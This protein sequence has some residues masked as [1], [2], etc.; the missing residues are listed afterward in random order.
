M[1]RC[2]YPTGIAMKNDMLLDGNSHI[3]FE[4]WKIWMKNDIL[5][6]GNS[7]IFFKIW[8]IRRHEEWWYLVIFLIFW[9]KALYFKWLWQMFE[10]ILLCELI[11]IVIGGVSLVEIVKFYMNAM[12]TVLWLVTIDELL[13]IHSIFY[14]EL[15]K[16]SFFPF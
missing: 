13:D 9:W 4:I 2:L 16:Y 15:L 12:T 7:R 8:K 3:F 10:T 14:D 11:R 1:P 6:D 5:L